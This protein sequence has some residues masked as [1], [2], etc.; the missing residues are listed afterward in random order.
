MAVAIPGSILSV[1]HGLAA[2]TFR[3][4]VIART[5]S[6]YR[7]DVVLVY[8]DP[9]TLRGDDRLLALLLAYAETPPHLRRRLY[10]LRRELRYAGLMPPLRTASHEAP[11]EPVEGALV[12]GVVD[13]REGGECRVFLGRLGEWRLRPCRARVGARVVVRL[14]DVSERAAEPASWGGIYSG[15]RVVRAASIADAVGWARRRGLL[16]VATSRLGECPG[17]GVICGIIS[18]ARSRGGVLLAFGGPK[19]GLLGQRAPVEFDYTINVVPGQGA[20]TV[21][22]EEALAAAL[23]AVNIAA[24]GGWC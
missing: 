7:V 4:G 21:R 19:R 24:G 8:K 5:L 18:G 3:A 16:A 12:E 14:V 2:K 15:Y 10:P 23:S 20:R 13:R 6:V 11:E 1:E 17:R 9:D 22:S